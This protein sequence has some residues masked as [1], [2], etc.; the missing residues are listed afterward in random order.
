MFTAGGPGIADCWSGFVTT[1]VDFFSSS[2]APSSETRV[3]TNSDLSG[4]AAGI[5]ILRVGSAC[6]E[7]AQDPGPMEC[8]SDR[9]TVGGSPRILRKLL[10]GTEDAGPTLIDSETCD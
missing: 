2:S 9:A 5:M 1:S 6:S 3:T 10:R 7:T 4:V 8:P